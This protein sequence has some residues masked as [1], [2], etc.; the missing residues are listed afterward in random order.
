MSE[1]VGNFAIEPFQEWGL[2][3]GF[4]CPGDGINGLLAAPERSGDPRMR[5]GCDLA[6]RF[7]FREVCFGL[8]R[9][10]YGLCRSLAFSRR[11]WRVAASDRQCARR[12]SRTGESRVVTWWRHGHDRLGPRNNLRS[13]GPHTAAQRVEGWGAGLSPPR[14]CPPGAISAR[15]R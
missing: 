5:N 10:T 14:S 3:L 15:P 7:R 12:R 1:N 6:A 2:E 9:R 4:A 13:G 11:A 8:R